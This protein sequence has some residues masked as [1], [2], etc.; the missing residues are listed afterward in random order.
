MKTIRHWFKKYLLRKKHPCGLCTIRRSVAGK[1]ESGL[2]E[3]FIGALE[4]SIDRSCLH[5]TVFGALLWLNSI[6]RMESL[7]INIYL[8]GNDGS[9]FLECSFTLAISVENISGRKT[10]TESKIKDRNERYNATLDIFY[11]ST[12][13]KRV[14]IATNS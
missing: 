13:L 7:L 3:S 12:I 6:S 1:N 11:K 8:V 5:M 10:K 14:V 2:V 9:M 4:I